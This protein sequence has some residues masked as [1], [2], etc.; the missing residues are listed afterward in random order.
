MSSADLSPKTDQWPLH[1]Q[2]LIQTLRKPAAVFSSS[3]APVIKSIVVF[4]LQLTVYDY[5]SFWFLLSIL[6][7]D[8]KGVWQDNRTIAWNYLIVDR[9]LKK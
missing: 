4:Q 5:H 1:K 6:Q 3:A 9:R 7:M 8:L 2:W